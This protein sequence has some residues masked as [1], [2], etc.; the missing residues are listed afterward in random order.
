[1]KQSLKLLPLL[2]AAALLVGCGA[3]S[4]APA[5]PTPEVTI[6][7]TAPT[8]EP[9]APTPTPQPT[10]RPTPTPLPTPVPEE[11]PFDFSQ[12]LVDG[13]VLGLEVTALGFDI[14]GNWVFHLSMEN[15]AAEIVSVHFLYQSINGIAI[16]SFKY[17]LA[18]GETAERLVRVFPSVLESFGSSTPTEWAF[19]LCVRSS[20]RVADPLLEEELRV[21]PFGEELAERYVYTPGEG[22]IVLMDNDL[23]TVYA[24]GY[25]QEGDVFALEYAAVSKTD[26]PLRLTLSEEEPCLL[27]GH[28]VAFL[29]NDTLG[30]RTV[31]IGYMPFPLDALEK[32]ESIQTLRFL[33]QLDNP[34]DTK[35]RTH[36][37][38][39]A[40]ELQPDYPLD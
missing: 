3:R 20:E 36:D 38:Q 17:R 7:T 10:P 21:C 22:D 12:T 26:T 5:E 28:E 15:R 9:P 29:L 19:T 23:I 30:G 1:M 11:I 2:L 18:V 16:E 33:L 4:E 13:E 34:D 27:N 8:P 37:R 39:A 24:T 25:S 31:L 40:V 32:A 6:E 35:D 14:N